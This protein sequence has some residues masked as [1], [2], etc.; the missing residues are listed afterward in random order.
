MTSAEFYDGLFLAK[1]E[2]GLVNVSPIERG[3]KYEPSL[4]EIHIARLKGLCKKFKK[5]K[6]FEKSCPQT[7][8]FER[9]F[10]RLRNY[11]K[12]HSWKKEFVSSV[13]SVNF[14]AMKKLF[15]VLSK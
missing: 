13:F 12:I 1:M 7:W 10:Y 9:D 2:R 14:N 6:K 15:D 11:M 8:D 5:A 4:E 3:R